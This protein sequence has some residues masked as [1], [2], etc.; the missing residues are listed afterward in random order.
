[1]VPLSRAV[2]AAPWLPV[3]GCLSFVVRAVA[4]LVS[5]ACTWLAHL[6]PRFALVRMRSP[7]HCG[8]LSPNG[9]S[10]MRVET[11]ISLFARLRIPSPHF[12]GSERLPQSFGVSKNIHEIRFAAIKTAFPQE[13][14]INSFT[15]LISCMF[16]DFGRTPRGA[17]CM[18][19]VARRWWPARRCLVV[20][21]RRWESDCR[22]DVAA[23]AAAPAAALPGG[24]LASRRFGRRRS[25]CPDLP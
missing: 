5:L 2:R 21:K 8:T 12:S 6:R 1:M 24:R 7:D 25:S 17:S 18:G 20:A 22:S 14:I 23:P 15:T 13:R 16:F 10:Q 9:K 4:R 19:P 11:R 3:V